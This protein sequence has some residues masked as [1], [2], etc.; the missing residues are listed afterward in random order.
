MLKLLK[1]VFI[2][3][4]VISVANAATPLSKE[5]TKNLES[6]DLFKKAQIK[7]N[8]AFDAG[9]VYLLNITVQNNPHKIYLTKNKKFL[10]QGEMVDTATGMPLMIPDMPVDLK[11]TLGKEVF[12]FGKGKDEYVL[13]TDPE[14]PYC[15]KFESYFD[16]IEDKVKMRVFF[17]PLPFHKNAK[18]ISLYIM[19]KKGYEASKEAMT[20]TTK[21]TPA[22]KNRKY[23][24]GE[25]EKL[26]KKL[27]EQMALASKLSVAG[28]PT[29][30]DK[31]GNK[32]SWV[33]ILQK[34]GV[35][36]E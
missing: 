5:Q 2:A 12:T 3:L 18:D 20:E 22:F 4:A 23:K 15:K 36:L 29:V 21:D 16:K 19:S 11:S 9:D 35:D 24:A 31:E 30:F 28:T 13:F 8:R 17:Y 25:L 33:K 7:V 6:L 14:C 34:Y 26:Q 32:V 10:I 27:D 1:T